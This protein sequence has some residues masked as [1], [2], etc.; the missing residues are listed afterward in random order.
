MAIKKRPEIF[1]F[2]G[3]TRPLFVMSGLEGENIQRFVNRSSLLNYFSTSIRMG[4]TCAISGESGSGKTSFLLKLMDMMKDST[5]GDYLQ[6]SFPVADPEKSKL[7]FLRRILNSILHIILMNDELL[8]QF[9]PDY[10]YYEITRLEYSIIVGDRIK[11]ELTNDD[12]IEGEINANFLD[13]LIPDEFKTKLNAKHKKE[14]GKIKKKNYPIHNENTLLE[15]I[16]YLVKGVDEPIVLFLDELDKVG[17]FPLE[18]PGWNKELIEMLELARDIMHTQ[19]LILV[20]ALH[21][22]LYEKFSHAK[23]SKGDISIIGLINFFKKLEG[24]DL[25]FAREA[26][27]A[28]LNFAGY[29]GSIDDLFE[30]GV[31]ETVLS[32]VKGNPRLFMHYLSDLSI[33]AF[34]EKQPQIT[35]TLLKNYFFEIDEEMNEKKWDNIKSTWVSRAVTQ[36]TTTS[37]PLISETV[38]AHFSEITLLQ[39]RRLEKVRLKKLSRI[40]ILAGLNN[41]GKTS[42][43]EAVYLLT[44]LN[45]IN[46]FFEM[47]AYRGK[48]SGDLNSK[49]LASNFLKPMEIGAIFNGKNT[50]I[51]IKA[52][53]T[54]E[55]IDKS[56][57]LTTFKL[58]ALH[59]GK[60]RGCEA[61][62][63]SNRESTIYYENRA[64]LCNSIMT[65]P[66]RDNEKE[67]KNAH[68]RAVE[69][70][71]I[72]IVVDFIKKNIDPGIQKIDMTTID[73]VS[74]FFVNSDD[75]DKAVDITNYGEGVRRVF[76][77]ALFF[78]YAKNGV[79]LIDE[80]ETAIHKSLLVDFSKFIQ[81]LA[82]KFNVQVFLTSHSKECIDSFI[83]ND[84]K[85]K[86]ITAYVMKVEDRQIKCKYVEGKRLE[87]LLESIDVDIREG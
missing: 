80:F 64:I 5:Y 51:L 10:I 37:P 3:I 1:D 54:K 46:A 35:Q 81:E 40:N 47:E 28:S 44:K 36:I 65:S 67:L 42:V 12:Q 87:K 82:E 25:A 56:G 66:Y 45:D 19:E 57:Y 32:A 8:T 76:E 26:V 22:E 20:F 85:T 84:Y 15:T 14:V 33:R 72:D 52:D 77:I 69:D 75:F 11:T 53:N 79:L 16:I 83:L 55:A 62:L 4:N 78:A 6:F 24:F 21:S 71:S 41:S 43:L 70:K 17:R 29:K 34:L 31:I 48:F 9:D 30:K 2:F 49:W 27:S 60:E 63:Y 38:S 50:T 13:L 18:S 86:D 58:T 39:F 23:T 7:Y 59:N 74:R 61:H 73:G 68:A